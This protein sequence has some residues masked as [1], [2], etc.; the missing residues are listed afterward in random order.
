MTTKAPNRYERIIETIFFAHHK[1]GVP[2]LDFDRQ[3]IEDVATRLKI[4]L[5]KNLGDLIYSFRHQR[6]PLPDSI[7]G[8]APPGMAWTI[9]PAGRSKYRFVLERN[10]R[11]VPNRQMEEIAVPDSTPGIIAL[12]AQTDEQALL[13]RIRYNRLI[14]L[15]SKTVAYSLQNHLRTTV[16]GIGQIETDEIYVGLNRQGAQFV[17]PVQAKTKRDKISLSQI[18]QDFAMCAEKFPG[19][20]CRPYAAQAIEETLIALFEFSKTAKGVAVVQERHYRLTP[21]D[22]FQPEQNEQRNKSWHPED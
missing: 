13:A 7:L 18:D 11:I 1:K 10:V 15:C 20:V 8:T 3:E 9:Q 6:S 5:P 4:K 17:F 16:R 22:Q 21:A 12:F 14:D 2:A 19:L